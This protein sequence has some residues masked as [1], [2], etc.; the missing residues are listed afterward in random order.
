MFEDVFPP[1][2]EKRAKG[3]PHAPY[4][5]VLNSLLYILI[6]G[7]RWCD[8]PSGGIW[9]SKSASH[10]WLKRWYSDGT[11]EHLQARILAITY[12]LRTR[13]ANGRASLNAD[14]K[15]LINWDFGAIDGSFSPWKRR[16]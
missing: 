5:H 6:T 13:S 2:P 14:E 8:L 12:V 15:G 1:E 7:C 3:M 16:R 10:R 11:F 9:A 4:R